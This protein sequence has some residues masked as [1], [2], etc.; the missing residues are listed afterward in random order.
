MTLKEIR[1]LLVLQSNTVIARKT[2][3][4]YICLHKFDG[5]AGSVHKVE[6]LGDLVK[7]HPFHRAEASLHQNLNLTTLLS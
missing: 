3:V 7:G 1:I 2:Q 6:N 5:A 4:K